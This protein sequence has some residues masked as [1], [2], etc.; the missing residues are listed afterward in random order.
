MD[1]QATATA[2]RT[3][4]SGAAAP[5][6]PGPAVAARVWEVREW[7]GSSLELLGTVEAVHQPGARI[8]AV[9]AFRVFDS[10]RQ[11]RLRVVPRR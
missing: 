4:G 7:I 3:T 2:H 5:A 1:H 11:A 6:A 8:K 9:T 10:Q